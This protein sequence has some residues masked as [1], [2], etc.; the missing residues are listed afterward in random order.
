MEQIYIVLFVGDGARME[1]LTKSQLV[2]R[3][4]K[5]WWGAT[6]MIDKTLFDTWSI[7]GGGGALDLMETGGL[8]IIKGDL[9][10]PEAKQVVKTWDVP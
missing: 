5:Q 3:L 7:R 6:Q 1:R 9:I 4:D 8:F 2:E 10:V